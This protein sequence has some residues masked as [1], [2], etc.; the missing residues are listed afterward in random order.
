MNFLHPSLALA[1]AIGVAIPIVIHLLMR[2]RRTP[3]PWAAMRFLLEAYK[4]QRRRMQV[5]QLLLLMARCLLVAL[6]GAAI[7]VPLTG[8]LSG[9]S[10]G[11]RSVVLVLDNSVTSGAADGSGKPA[12][13]RSK[14]RAL[15][16]L[17]QLTSERGDAAGLVTLGGPADAQVMPPSTDLAGVRGLVERAALTDARADLPGALERIAS[18]FAAAPPPPGVSRQIV[19]LSELRAGAA[20]AREPLPSIAGGESLL[21]ASAPATSELDNVAIASVSPLR[22]VLIGGAD[23]A[24]GT[25]PVTVMLRRSGPGVN[26]PASSLVRV[27]VLDGAGNGPSEPAGSSVVRWAPGQETAR[28]SVPTALPTRISGARLVLEAS[29]DRDAI[30]ADNVRSTVV[31]SRERIQIAVLDTRPTSVRA[32][33]GSLRPADWFA[34]ALDPATGSAG[35]SG[36][37]GLRISYEPPRALVSG[38]SSLAGYD[39]ALVPDPRELGDPEWAKLRAFADG[40]GLVM[41]APP[42]DA[43]AQTWTE[44]FARAMGLTWTFDRDPTTPSVPLR[45]AEEV[46]RE[47]KGVG[48]S[49][50]GLI[51]AELPELSKAVSVSRVLRV[52]AAPEDVALSL[53]DG[54]PLIVAAV[55]GGEGSG[56]SAGLVVLLT[57][58]LDLSWTDLPAKPLSVPLIQELVRQG[59][60]RQLGGGELV[61]GGPIRTAAG[62]SELRPVGKGSSILVDASGKA[63]Q[64]I[65]GAGLYAGLDARG[66]ELSLLAVNP[67]TRGSETRVLAKEAAEAWLSKAAGAARAGES[68]PVPGA[69]S[70]TAFAW[71]DETMALP[72]GAGGVGTQPRD[73]TLSFLLLLAAAGVA[74]IETL[75]ARLVS[76]AGQSRRASAL[77]LI[78]PPQRQEAA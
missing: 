43:G 13:E 46:S 49:L 77:T 24:A 19:V 4:K 65:R 39:A 61:A 78:P 44:S 18:S 5:E 52:T 1:G 76:H 3:V 12:L 67:D 50:L 33:I 36:G 10:R 25:D 66:R 71:L 14:Q 30:D 41:V 29:I 7:A 11:P 8:A 59:V 20:D 40:G 48:P 17:D 57:T 56:T 22:H 69:Q 51:A 63:T 47:A 9:K 55:P 62:T 58:A 28:V 72:Q 37:A 6:I 53:T 23:G 32:S 26:S 38:G 27:R 42:P 68:D 54:S 73:T 31:Q 16:V 15:A 34:L 21:L 75:L 60:G 74:L 2:R 45:L 35:V 64:P 70:P